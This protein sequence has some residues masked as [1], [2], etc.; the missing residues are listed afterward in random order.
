M[1]L[2]THSTGCLLPS[3]FSLLEVRLHRRVFVYRHGASLRGAAARAAPA[4]ELESGRG[5]GRQR[6]L[7]ALHELRRADLAAVK[8][9]ACHGAGAAAPDGER[10]L[11]EEGGRDVE[12]VVDAHRARLL[13]AAARAAPAREDRAGGGRGRQRHRRVQLVVGRALAPAA[14][15]LV[16]GADVAV[17][18][19][20]D[21]D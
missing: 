9:S 8:T 3:A 4:G 10:E 1:P 18:A 21:G 20:R 13:S 6:D 15:E 16:G 5:R 19:L 7:R 12:R 2:L 17:A 11:R 14:Y